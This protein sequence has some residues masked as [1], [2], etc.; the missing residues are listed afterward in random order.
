MT[1]HGGLPVV[2]EPSKSPRLTFLAGKGVVHIL[3]RRPG[4][5]PIKIEVSTEGTV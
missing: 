4:E 3:V 2:I 5:E 1:G